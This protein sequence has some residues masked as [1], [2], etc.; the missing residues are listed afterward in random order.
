MPKKKRTKELDY[1]YTRYVSNDSPRTG[2]TKPLIM[3]IHTTE[4]H[5]YKGLKDL[6]GL[7]SWFDNPAASASS[8]VATDKEGNIARYV[9]DAKKAWTCASFNS[10]SLNIEQIGFAKFSTKLWISRMKQLKATA[11]VLA[12]WSVKYHIP[13]Y[14]GKVKGS[15]VVKAGVLRHSD[16]GAAGGSHHDPGRGYPLALVLRMAR[17]YKKHGW[18]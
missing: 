2:E 11:K 17:W 1:D 15:K 7:G 10:V 14:K 16:L 9:A 4:G 8:H 3:V 6:K 12:Y 13:L 5:D 18:K